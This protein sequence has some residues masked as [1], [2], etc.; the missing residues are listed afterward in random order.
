MRKLL[1]TGLAAGLSI[2]PVPTRAVPQ[3][4]ASTTSDGLSC[5]FRG[6]TLLDGCLLTQTRVCGKWVGASASLG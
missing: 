4:A 5:I 2:V 6:V 3:T 1:T